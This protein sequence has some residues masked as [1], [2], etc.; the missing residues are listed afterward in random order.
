MSCPV[1]IRPCRLVPLTV[2]S[3]RSK[4][5]RYRRLIEILGR[6]RCKGDWDGTL[7]LRLELPLLGRR[8]RGVAVRLRMPDP[9]LCKL[10]LGV[11]SRCR[12]LTVV[13]VLRRRRWPVE[14]SS[15]VV[16]VPV[17]LEVVTVVEGVRV[18]ATIRSVP[19]RGLGGAVCEEYESEKESTEVARGIKHTVR[20]T[21][22]DERRQS[23]GSCGLSC[24][25]KKPKSEKSDYV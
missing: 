7:R 13:E 12:K 10:L 17:S 15:A 20:A 14:P 2:V 1:R 24:N 3:R 5:L 11:A 19:R 4:L 6:A 9:R 18:T 25:R 23:Y 22:S 21:H 8:Q 16:A